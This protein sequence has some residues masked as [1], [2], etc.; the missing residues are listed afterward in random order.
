MGCGFA[1]HLD[2]AICAETTKSFVSFL[3]AILLAKLRKK[4]PIRRLSKAGRTAAPSSKL[5]GGIAA[6]SQIFNRLLSGM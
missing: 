1:S 2:F 4:V 5:P 6:L 3:K